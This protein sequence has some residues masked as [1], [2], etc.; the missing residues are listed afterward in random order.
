[1]LD[2]PPA[3]LQES[4][5]SLAP[6]QPGAA[7]QFGTSKPESSH[8]IPLRWLWSSQGSCHLPLSSSPA[9][10]PLRAGLYA[11]H[12]PGHIRPSVRN[13]PPTGPVTDMLFKANQAETNQAPSPSPT[14]RLSLPVFSGRL[15]GRFSGRFLC[16]GARSAIHPHCPQSALWPL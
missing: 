16:L 4:P 6:L 9:W 2:Q 13:H 10:D 12:R 14:L 8:H 7:I 1:M 3:C 5:A 11:R 15:K